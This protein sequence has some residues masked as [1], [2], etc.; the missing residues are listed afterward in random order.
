MQP[1][2][3]KH[4]YDNGDEMP[5]L[6]LGTWKSAPGDAYR[7]VKA[8]L[9]LGYRHIDCAAIYG[10]EAEIG[11]ALAEAFAEGSLRREELWVTSKL[12]NDAHGPEAV[13]PAL[14]RTLA[15][16]QLAYLDLYLMHWP[17]A[18]RAGVLLP[19]GAGDY[20]ALDELPLARTWAAMEPAVGLGLCRHLGV[21]NFSAVK[22]RVLHAGATVRPEVNQIELHPYLQQ[23]ELLA[24]CQ[25]LGVHATAYSPLGSGDRPAGLKSADEPVLLQ[26]PAIAEIAGVHGVSAAQVLI[27]WALGRGTSVIPKSVDPRR[28]QE[29]LVAAAVRLTGEDMRRIAGL[30]RRRRYLDGKAWTAGGVYSVAG[31]W[32]E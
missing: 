14:R 2:T 15:D 7:A 24:A 3:A 31:L 9:A 16:L 27:A 18:H 6:G 5:M 22:L 21:S 11:R 32:D 17:I 19:R 1:T 23:P 10:N 12:W 20:V 26:D 30:E 25:E 28:M 4:R 13:L 29:N 8:A